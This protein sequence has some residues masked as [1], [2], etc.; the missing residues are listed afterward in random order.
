MPTFKRKGELLTAN[1]WNSLV[2]ATQGRDPSG[3][4]GGAIRS[5]AGNANVTLGV[6]IRLVE[7]I[8]RA[9]KTSREDDDFSN[10]QQVWSQECRWVTIEENTDGYKQDTEDE[11]IFVY[12]PTHYRRLNGG[13]Q[14][15]VDH[16][17]A[18]HQ[19]SDAAVE[20]GCRFW[21]IYNTESARWE[22]LCQPNQFVRFSLTASLAAGGSAAATVMWSQAG[23]DA[24]SAG[25]TITVFDWL[26]GA[27]AS[28]GDKGYAIWQPDLGRWEA[29]FPDTTAQITRYMTQVC[30][31]TDQTVTT[32]AETVI[33]FQDSTNLKI[34]DQESWDDT[35]DGVA[36]GIV[37]HQV[38]W[39]RIGYAVSW[40]GPT[41]SA[42]GSGLVIDAGLLFVGAN[43]DGN[44]ASYA[45]LDCSKCKTFV[46]HDNPTGASM[47]GQACTEFLFQN[48]DDP[49]VIKLLHNGTGTTNSRIF[50]GQCCVFWAEYLGHNVTPDTVPT[51]TP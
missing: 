35:G 37:L 6:Q 9:E 15:T 16:P 27:S 8:A 10:G 22:A 13:V 30:K 36:D 21:A 19:E 25:E 3:G 20:K 11:T 26:G 44:T 40:E 43:T 48:G 50:L 38:G 1:E 7:S 28:S 29:T 45:T 39:Y 33:I 17:F 42:G 47:G 23:T 46:L 41:T 14:T 51:T 24:P 12:F 31:D 5:V 2:E 49:F 18:W 32:G 34:A 4:S